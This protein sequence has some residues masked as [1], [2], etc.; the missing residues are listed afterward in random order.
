[1][2][3][4]WTIR[5]IILFF[6]IATFS[7]NSKAQ[8]TPS[9]TSLASSCPVELRDIHVNNLS[10]RVRNTSGKRIVGL[11][12]N[13]ALSDA[14]EHWIWLHWNYDLS[15]RLREFGWNRLI[16]EGESKKLSWDFVDLEHEHGGGVVL[17]LSS[18]LFADGSTWDED[19]D[20][21]TCKAIWFNN[22]KKGFTK[23]VLL[24]RRQ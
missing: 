10:V 5:P 4:C 1:M 16:R 15:A 22:H 13:V 18:I 20:T 23:P 3:C 7:L 12:F 19:A 2:K 24:P 6:A 21:I 17:V 14:T 11:V 9:S 8:T